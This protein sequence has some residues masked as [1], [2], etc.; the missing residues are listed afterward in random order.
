[1]KKLFVSVVLLSLLSSVFA[2]GLKDRYFEL[3]FDMQASASNSSFFLPD[4]LKEELVIDLPSLSK[5]V[6]KSGFSM[7]LMAK[8]SFSMNLDLRKVYVGLTAGVETQGAFTISKDLFDFL[9][10]GL[11]L[12]ETLNVGVTANADMFLYVDATVGFFIKTVKIK[13]KPSAFTPI[14]H[15]EVDKSNISIVNTPDGSIKLKMN[16]DF[17]IYSQFNYQTIQNLSSGGMAGLLQVPSFSSVGFDLSASADFAIK[18][19]F[20]VTGYL[21]V[22]ILPA[23]LSNRVGAGVEVNADVNMLD[24][25]SGNG[26]LEYDYKFNDF[27]EKSGTKK[28]S[29]PLKAGAG[30]IWDGLGSSVIFYASG[31]VGMRYPFTSMMIV[32]PEYVAGVDLS[33]FNILGATISMQ[34]VDKVFANKFDVFLNTRVLQVN[35]GVS[36]ESA[37][38]VGSFKLGGAGFHLGLSLGF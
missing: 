33:L 18:R 36:L 8:P 24:A 27:E 4:F 1:M 2:F 17:D 34:Y 35:A 13:V 5:S 6:P 19:G 14:F 30:V 11:A 28:V 37:S 23:T 38:F 32:Y 29:R 10:D 20:T 21:R 9:S 7:N 25:A 26:G 31:G 16:S 12:N 15:T 3:N 22:P